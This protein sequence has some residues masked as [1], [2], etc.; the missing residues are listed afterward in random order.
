MFQQSHCTRDTSEP[1]RSGQVFFANFSSF[2][3]ELDQTG[4]KS[5]LMQLYRGGQSVACITVKHEMLKVKHPVPP[6]REVT[7]MNE[8]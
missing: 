3:P 1:L 7:R 6:L 4:R 2:S 8:G 5:W